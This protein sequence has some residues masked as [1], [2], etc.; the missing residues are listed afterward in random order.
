[1]ETVGQAPWKA[2]GG[3]RCGRSVDVIGNAVEA[4]CLLA[5]VQL[6]P[7]GAR[8]AVAGLTDAARV[9][10]PVPFA[11]VEQ[12]VIAGLSAANVVALLRGG[13]PCEEQRHVRMAD[14]GNPLRLDVQAGIRLLGGEHVLPD[15]IAR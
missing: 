6:Q 8:V 7:G 11:E 14:Q 5:G 10:Q 13:G 12:G 1:V 3:N 4:R 15:R 2:G 9:D